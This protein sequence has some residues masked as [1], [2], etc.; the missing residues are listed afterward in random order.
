M[1]LKRT[2]SGNGC[3]WELAEDLKNLALS[4]LLGVFLFR[5]TSLVFGQ[6]F[7][8]AATLFDN[9]EHTDTLLW[10]NLLDF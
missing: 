2:P 6:S 3:R 9:L 10:S 1:S 5:R 8:V 7:V 4:K